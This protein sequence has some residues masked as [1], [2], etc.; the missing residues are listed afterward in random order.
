MSLEL[1]IGPMFAGKSSAVQSIIRRH[2]ALG[3]SVCVITHRSD[4]RYSETP[5]I[6]NH[7]AIAIPAIGCDRLFEISENLDFQQCRLV[8]VEEAQFFSDLVPFVLKA[9]E[10]LQKHVVVVGL[11]G[12]AMRRPFG[13]VLQLIPYCDRIMKLT[14]M[15]SEC[16]DGTPALFS[17]ACASDAGAAAAIGTTCVGAADKYIPLCRRHFLAKTRS[18]VP[19]DW[20]NRYGC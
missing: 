10:E 6:V 20:A 11:D 4:T 18:P 2:R 16:R 5:A 8:V 15:C 17:F 3:W 19:I 9:V 7:D 12:D 1:I 13:D 14:A